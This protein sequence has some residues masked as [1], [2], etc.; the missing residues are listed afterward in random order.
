MNACISRHDST[1]ALAS[2]DKNHKIAFCVASSDP[3]RVL[4]DF[5]KW[6]SGPFIIQYSN[7]CLADTEIHHFPMAVTRTAWHW[8]NE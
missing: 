8:Q 5:H 1:H 3:L 6:K 4:I 7:A 2:T